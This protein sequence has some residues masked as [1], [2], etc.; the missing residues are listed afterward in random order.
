[1][2]SIVSLAERVP[3][4]T[5][6]S[7]KVL[8][9]IFNCV[10]IAGVTLLVLWSY[11]VY[12]VKFTIPVLI[13][14]KVILGRILFITYHLLATLFCWSYYKC[15]LT[16]AP[17]ATTNDLALIEAIPQSS[18]PILRPLAINNGKRRFCRIC[19]V[20]KLNRISHCSWCERCIQKMDHHCPWVGNCIGAH[21]YKSF[22]LMLFYCVFFSGFVSSSLVLCSSYNIKDTLVLIAVAFAA[23]FGT[24]I[25][26]VFHLFLLFTNRTTLE[27][28]FLL[29]E[30]R[31]CTFN[32]DQRIYDR[33]FKLNFTSVFGK[34][35]HL[36]LFPI[37]P[38]ITMESIVNV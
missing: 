1:M 10:P 27:C 26:F 12:V 2:K 16:S 31:Q 24:G 29:A 6:R 33:G 22:V 18:P 38:D 3:G 32:N 25:L 14:Q 4:F 8:K 21:N 35:P 37:Q 20:L 28:A 19:K 11:F 36:W 15:A 34:D 9:F 5:Q 30:C 17:L 7:V 23:A 13:P